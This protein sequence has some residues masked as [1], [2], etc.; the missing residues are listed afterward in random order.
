M[1]N[2]VENNYLDQYRDLKLFYKEDV[3]D[4]LLSLTKSY[5]KMK[6]YYPIQITDLRF[7]V[8]HMS[9]K[10]VRIFEE[11][12]KNSTNTSTYVFLIKQRETKKISDGNI[13]ISVEVV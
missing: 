10:I 2:F 8:D 11:Y 7:Q 13:I 1:D 3:G 9:P 12:D 6:N 5:D 4:Q